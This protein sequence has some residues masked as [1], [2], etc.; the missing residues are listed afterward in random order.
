MIVFFCSFNCPGF[1]WNTTA[2]LSD[3]PG[4][5]G[6]LGLIGVVQPQLAFT[7]KITNGCLPVLLTLKLVLLSDS[8]FTVPKS[9][10]NR[11]KTKV[12]KCA[13]R[14][15]S[16]AAASLKVASKARSESSLA[17]ILDTISVFEV[18]LNSYPLQPWLHAKTNLNQWFNYGLNPTTWTRFS[19]QQIKLFKENEMK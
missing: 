15:F 3:F 16:S 10:S 1:G 11:S 18:S 6:F 12:V 17:S 7:F 19:L 8:A 4:R 2:I 13:K 14:S 5:I 9:C